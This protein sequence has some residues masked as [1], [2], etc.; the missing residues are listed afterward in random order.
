MKTL[1]GFTPERQVSSAHPQGEHTSRGQKKSD[2]KLNSRLHGVLYGQNRL[3][4]FSEYR[5]NI[6]GVYEL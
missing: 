6:I 4:V 1:V 2:R 5:L 3:H